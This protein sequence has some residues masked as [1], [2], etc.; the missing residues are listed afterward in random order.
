MP[1]R[2]A[3]LLPTGETKQQ[4]RRRLEGTPR[5]REFVDC[6]E[7]LKQNGLSPWP[8]WRKAAEMFPKVGEDDFEGEP[9]EAGEVEGPEVSVR[10]EHWKD[11][12]VPSDECI[13]WVFEALGEVKK[14]VPADAP[15]A[16]AWNLYGTCSGRPD[17]A[18]SFYTNLWSK[19]IKPGDDRE[20][21]EASTDKIEVLI[22]KLEA[23]MED[24]GEEHP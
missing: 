19:T 12:G 2:V 14:L 4:F 6:R 15:S 17:M 10:P 23:A 11:K 18:W 5:W 16:G 13:R 1:N 7:R 8:A 3:T 9:V 24:K 21:L 20:R 22:E